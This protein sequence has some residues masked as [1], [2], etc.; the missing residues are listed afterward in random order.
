M[1]V[2]VPDCFAARVAV[3]QRSSDRATFQ[4]LPLN[5]M[6]RIIIS[7]STMIFIACP[8]DSGVFYNCLVSGLNKMA[9][10]GKLGK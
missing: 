8:E 9:I 4:Q 7:V 6:L 2:G 10:H 3:L 1:P 5:K